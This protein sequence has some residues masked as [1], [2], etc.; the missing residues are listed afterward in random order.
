MN[1]KPISSNYLETTSKH[2]IAKFYVKKTTFQLK[3]GNFGDFFF[4][5]SLCFPKSLTAAVRGEKV[6]W[7]IISSYL[8]MMSRTLSAT[9][10]IE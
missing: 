2:F 4:Y 7:S 1:M 3:V 6:A 8:S 10:N 9:V 5:W